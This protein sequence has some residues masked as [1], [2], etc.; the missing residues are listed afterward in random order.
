MGPAV[1]L[2]HAQDG[3]ELGDCLRGHRGAPVDVQ[4]ELAVAHAVVEHRLGDELLGQAGRLPRRHQ[5]GH[6]VAAVDVEHHVEVE[7]VPPVGP[8]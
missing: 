6:R 3:Q 2:Q 7:P 1:A 8:G 5:P 4:G